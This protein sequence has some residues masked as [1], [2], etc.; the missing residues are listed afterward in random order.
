MRILYAFPEPLPLPRARGGQVV[1]AVH[2]LAGTGVE[3]ELAYVPAEDECDPFHAYGLSC[4]SN[5]HLHPLSRELPGPLRALGMRSNKLFLLRLHRLVT[6]LVRTR[7]LDVIVV[8]H[9][10]IAASLLKRFPNIPLVYEAH[11]VFTDTTYQAHRSKIASLEA[12]VV[13]RA[14]LVIANSRGTANRLRTLF[15]PRNIEVL[16]NGV[17]LGPH[18]PPPKPWDYAGKNVVYSGSL[19]AWKGVDDLIAAAAHLPGF[20]ITII[21]GSLDQIEH[22]CAAV[23]PTGA[24]VQFLGHLPQPEVLRH[25]ENACIAVLPNRPDPDSAFTSPLKLFEYMGAGCAIVATDLPVFREIL[26][27]HDVVWVTAGHPSSLATGIRTLASQP[28]QAKRMGAHLR[29]IAENYTWHSR[30]LRMKE[31]LREV[32]DTPLSHQHSS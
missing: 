1:N 17:R 29:S 23:D 6:K 14:T 2:S 16:A 13:N 32:I 10:K 27:D 9:L 20:C 25:L 8:R 30:A 3:I 19:F 11:Q 28:D 12:A 26:G 4:P 18:P 31:L 7:Q 22:I 15:S 5:V 24:Q 21:G